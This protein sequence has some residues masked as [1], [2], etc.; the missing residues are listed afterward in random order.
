MS[1]HIIYNSME[2]SRK[3][4]LNCLRILHLNKLSNLSCFSDSYKKRFDGQPD[5]SNDIIP[6]HSSSFGKF[7]VIRYHY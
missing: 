5:T 7:P 6:A 2:S 4:S 1:T 3:L